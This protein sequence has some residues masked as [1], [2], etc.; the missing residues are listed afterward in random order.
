MQVYALWFSLR[1]KS[2]AWFVMSVLMVTACTSQPGAVV[3]IDSN[4]P[5]FTPV[6]VYVTPTTEPS[7]FPTIDISTEV[8]T[9]TA[10]L[11]PTVT[12]DGVAM[13]AQCQSA[14]LAL[15]ERAGE[16]CL[17]S[18]SGFFCNGGATPA[19]QPAGNI[20]NSF[21]VPGA[22]VDADLIDSITL[23]PFGTDARGGVVWVHLSDTVMMNGLLL[24]DV[25][26]TNASEEGFPK[27][28][29]FT[30]E[31]HATP[32]KCDTA[33]PSAFVVQGP[34]GASTRL[35]INGTSVDLDGSLIVQTSED[36][37]ATSS[38]THFI[39]IEGDA[40]VTV[41]G[42]RYPLV[43]GQQ[44]SV[45]YAVSNFTFPLDL[46]AGVIPL[47]AMRIDGV[48]VLLMD[49]P[50]L[51]PQ[52][53][54][55]LTQGNVNMRAEPGI[56][57]RLLYQVPPDSILSILGTNE[58]RDWFHIR[59]GNGETGWMSA[60][61][62]VHSIGEINA[63]YD[64]TPEP[65]Q[66][67]GA[68]GNSATVV[69]AQGGNLRVGPDTEFGTVATLAQ[70]SEVTLLSRSPYSPWVKVDTGGQVGW[71][72]LITLETQAA[73]GFLPIDYQAPL[74]ARPTP[75]PVFDFGGGHAYPDPRG[76]S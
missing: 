67:L 68:L 58:E 23:P 62:L 34:Y 61:L 29:S 33:P 1:R 25:T 71:M 45:P 27:W 37:D 10:T 47:Q 43:A 7:P 53:G 60:E 8:P 20:A 35:V 13:Q 14:L 42:R 40:T 46:P 17:G 4:R 48:P 52:P 36:A 57:G 3:E 22:L 63:V 31:T 55:A 54:Y 51:L 38:Y 12:P 2:V 74:P 18:P 56:E 50:V 39:V 5:T 76:G 65:P 44:I 9:A 70:G 69:T 11:T 73:I 21:A 30:I 59:L 72:A 66:R 64:A 41:L 49:R 28:Q 16:L 6:I 32:Q 26:I 15:Y 19:L 24:G 75:V